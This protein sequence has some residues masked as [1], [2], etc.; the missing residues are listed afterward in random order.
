[1]AAVAAAA[2]LG[3]ACSADGDDDDG[4]QATQ[5]SG[6]NSGG[7]GS[8]SSG[9]GGDIFAGS[10]GAGASSGVGGG[11]AGLSSTAEKVPLDIFIML[12]RSGSMDG[13]V[14]G[15]G[16][17]WT[18]TTSAISAFV[19]SPDAAGIGVGIQYFGLPPGGAQMCPT[20][21]ASDADCGVCGPCFLVVGQG[22]CLGAA[23]GDSCDPAD[24]AVAAVE[25]APLPGVGPAIVSSMAAN[26]PSTGTPTKPAL[27]GA[28]THAKAWATANPSHVVV[29]LLA[30]DGIPE[31]CDT[32]LANINAVAAA[33]LNG[34][35]SI[36]TFVIGVG[37]ELGALNGI[38][39]AGGTDQAYLV[40]T[41]ANAQ[42][43]FLMAM[44]DIQ[45]KALPC[46]YT[47]PEPTMGDLDYDKVNVEYTPGGGGTAEFIPK[48]DNAA[49]CPASGDGWYYDDA[50]PP[51][52]ILLCPG[53]CEKLSLDVEGTVN[54][55][56]GCETIAD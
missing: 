10:S 51:S 11:C 12:D 34:M 17:K 8:D 39:A 29:V 6:A 49:A 44:Q 19:N 45:G 40:D 47:I 7:S 52:Q 4:F 31:A 14:D 16:T 28:I 9:T 35:P 2:T 50:A 23:G 41:N 38:A 48:V 43:E 25:I 54:I 36:P 30:T 42:Q 32:N 33:G 3:S 37:S 20:M 26:S 13:S 55:V 1:M 24:Y 15:G 46:A 56:L 18:A 27:E 53:T 21:C 5:G 22:F